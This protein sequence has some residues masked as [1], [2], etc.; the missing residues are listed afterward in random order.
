MEKKTVGLPPWP[1]DWAKH[2]YAGTI[3]Q[4]DLIPSGIPYHD[5]RELLAE[6]NTL[7]HNCIKTWLIAGCPGQ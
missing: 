6:F 7:R 2:Q 4:A 3:L 5:S 1:G